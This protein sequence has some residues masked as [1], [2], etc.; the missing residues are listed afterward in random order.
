MKNASLGFYAVVTLIRSQVGSKKNCKEVV[1]DN[2]FVVMN[3]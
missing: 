2:K 3:A 1:S